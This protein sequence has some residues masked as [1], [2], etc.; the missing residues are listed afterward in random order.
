MIKQL[1][2]PTPSAYLIEIA[3]NIATKDIP[4][5][6]IIEKFFKKQITNPTPGWFFIE[7]ELREQF[8]KEY[9]NILSD[10][11]MPTVGV[12]PNISPSTLASLP[13]HVD[14]ERSLSLNYIIEPG[15]NNVITKF[16]HTP[17]HIK[18]E[19]QIQV[20]H[21]DNLKL[22]CSLVTQKGN[23][24][25]L[26]VQKFHSVENVETTRIIL[27]VSMRINYEIFLEKYKHLVV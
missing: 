27:S 14:R 2:L 17:E 5:R 8:I 13:P 10:H 19:N 15:G 16:Y 12:F 9:N 11:H 6:D 21:Y 4:E 18:T 1:L 24:Y 25:V 3:K 26:N 20:D 7:S 23:W 22:D